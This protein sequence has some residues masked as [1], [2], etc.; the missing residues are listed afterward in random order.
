MLLFSFSAVILPLLT[1]LVPEII[2][3]KEKYMSVNK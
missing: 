3:P 1:S 2:C